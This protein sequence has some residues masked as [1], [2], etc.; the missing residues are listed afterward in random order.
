MNFREPIQVTRGG[1]LIAA[2][3]VAVALSAVVA[4]VVILVIGLNSNQREVQRVTRINRQA[5]G[6]LQQQ[7]DRLGKLERPTQEQL[8]NAALRALRAIRSCARS[9]SCRRR[10]PGVRQIA[11][12]I[13]RGEIPRRVRTR[14]PPSGSG[15]SSTRGP[16]PSSPNRSGSSKPAGP[17]STGRRPQPTTRPSQPPASRPANP[18]SAPSQPQNPPAPPQTSPPRPPVV[19]VPP[20]TVPP[21]TVPPITSPPVALPGVCVPAPGVVCPKAP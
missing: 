18:P 7:N 15:P 12:S 21:I 9:P 8:T 4:A 20:V 16:V 6:E 2:S 19:S 3:A 10:N 5:I 1:I 11:R 17:T 13:P 14:R